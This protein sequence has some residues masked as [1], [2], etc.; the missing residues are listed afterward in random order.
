MK[1]RSAYLRSPWQCELREV[2]L[3]DDVPDG[4]ALIRVEACG[5]CG[6]DLSN[7]ESQLEDWQPFGH[8]IAGVIDKLGTHAGGLKIGDKV[9]LESAS[10]CGKCELCRSGRVDLCN[11]APHFWNAGPSL[12]FSDY[13]LAPVCGIVPYEGMT[14]ETACLAEP[15]GVAYDMVKTAE[16]EHGNRVCVIGPGPIGLMAIPIAL[17]SGAD[18]VVCIGRPGNRARL[19]AA[20]KLGAETLAA[21]RPWTEY[22]ELRGRFDRVLLTAPVQTIPEAIPLLAYGGILSYIGIGTG[23]GMI[24]FDANDFHY[25]KLQLRASF[26]SPALYYPIVLKMLKSGAIPADTIIS[27]RL[28][29][30]EI[31]R[32]MKLCREDKGE[33]VKVVVT[34]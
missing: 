11:K 14:P 8:E 4:Y 1:T 30:N 10:Y 16:I 34:P 29:L 21:D 24:R 12:G 5:I 18:Q 28:P 27:H 20:A 15:A 17:R 31:G 13:L 3:P 26:A 19:E 7:A 22:E 25:R 32:A 6:T 9:V 2:D 33:T 23:S